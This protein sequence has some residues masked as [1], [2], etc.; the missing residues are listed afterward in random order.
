MFREE[1]YTIE[2][3]TKLIINTIDLDHILDIDRLEEEKN[4]PPSEIFLEGLKN[5]LEMNGYSEDEINSINS[6]EIRLFR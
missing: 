5:E 4:M 3:V 6:I 1:D 2:L